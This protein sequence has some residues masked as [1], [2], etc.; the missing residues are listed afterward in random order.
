MVTDEH[1]LAHRLSRRLKEIPVGTVAVVQG[2]HLSRI[3][4]G[5]W[6]LG[7]LNGPLLCGAY[8][9]GLYLARSILDAT[10]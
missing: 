4:E 9:A 1:E 10:G 8:H 5:I 7:Y 3:S 2:R 6:R